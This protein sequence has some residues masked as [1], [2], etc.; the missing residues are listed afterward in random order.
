MEHGVAHT[1][2]GGCVRLTAE[3]NGDTLRV[4][5]WDNGPGPAPNRDGVGLSNTRARLAELYGE[6]HRF[7]LDS[8]EQGGTAV[9]IELPYRTGGK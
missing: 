4:A 8:G 5:L 7:E 2:D 1:R 6:R 9:T 3:R